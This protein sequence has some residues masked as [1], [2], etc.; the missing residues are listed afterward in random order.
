MNPT[1]SKIF[2]KILTLLGSLWV[3]LASFAMRG[4]P[5]GL[6]AFFQS[7]TAVA[8]DLL[9][10]ILLF[11]KLF[12]TPK[13][14]PMRKFQIFVYFT[15]KLVCLGFLAITLKRLKNDPHLPVG[16]A[17]LF[18]GVGPLVAGVLAKR[19]MKKE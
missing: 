4:D 15:F 17:V 10:L 11:W 14:N 18:M 2:L 12:F 13:S 3:F 16:F 8:F 9:F 1:E 6:N 7:F 5:Q 19:G